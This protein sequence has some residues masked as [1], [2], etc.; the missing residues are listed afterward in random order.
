MRTGVSLDAI[1][2]LIEGRHDNPYSVLGPHPI[3]DNGRRALAVRTFLPNAKQVWLLDKSQGVPRP[4]R[5][6]HP[7]GLYEAICPADDTETLIPY[8]F[9]V[10]RDGGEIA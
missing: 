6:I 10:V 3:E 2:A 7:A 4:M 9:R 8:E 5:R 1:G